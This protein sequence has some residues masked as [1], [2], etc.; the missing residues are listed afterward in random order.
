M[1]HMDCALNC[2]RTTIGAMGDIIHK[3]PGRGDCDLSQSDRDGKSIP[4][5]QVGDGVG[6]CM[7]CSQNPLFKL[8]LL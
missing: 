3:S 1:R 5:S 6:R 4:N 2:I 7:G 8:I